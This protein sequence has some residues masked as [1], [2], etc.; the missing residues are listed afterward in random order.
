MY[1]NKEEKVYQ[2]DFY[3][4]GICTTIGFVASHTSSFCN[5]IQQFSKLKKSQW[6]S[7]K[8]KKKKISHVSSLTS[9][10][11]KLFNFFNSP[12]PSPIP[13]SS[14]YFQ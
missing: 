12:T 3:A 11:K 14:L 4:T 1:Q 6:A 8:L 10:Q 13:P 2:I 9:R 7:S 5:S